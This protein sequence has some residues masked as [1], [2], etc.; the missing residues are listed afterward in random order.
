MIDNSGD[1]KIV[2]SKG[3]ISSELW[4][5]LYQ[6]VSLIKSLEPWKIFSEVDLAE[7]FL[8]EKDEPYYCSV[9]G[10]FH[11]NIGL[12][13]YE[14]HNGLINFS[15]YINSSDFPDYIA[16]SRRNC[17]SC[18]F[19]DAS[20]IAE[21][22]SSIIEKLNYNFSD[23]DIPLFRNHKAGFA[24]WYFS[25]GDAEIAAA[26]TEEFARAYTELA[27]CGA[28]AEMDRGERICTRYDKET[29]SWIN[30]LLSPVEKIEV[31]T[32]SCIITDEILI[33]RLSKKPN[34]GVSLEF[35]LPY[36]PITVENGMT[37]KR[38]FYPR[39][40]TLCDAATLESIERYFVDIRENQKDTVLGMIVKYIEENGRPDE[41]F[42]RDAEILG[43]IV[44]LCKEID[45]SVHLTN[46]LRA[47]D[48]FMQEIII[49]MNRGEYDG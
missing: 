6:T 21:R 44:N 12:C 4:G 27:A 1:I 35:D 48:Y 34:N 16:E 3:D 40:A 23:E 43:I 24:P 41:I 15:S 19:V 22:D 47:V 11:G 42:V 33:R 49:R 17:L 14:G 10:M 31:I 28:L 36:I 18:V 32:E 8:P 25:K 2:N 20:H 37:E 26:V 9:L 38:P 5:K 46:S 29:E 30:E 39:I 7:I 45:V 13:I